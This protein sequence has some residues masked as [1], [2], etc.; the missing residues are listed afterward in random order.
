MTIDDIVR[1]ESPPA[2]WSEGEKIPWDDPAFSERMLREHLSQLHDGASRRMEHIDAHVRWLHQSV[3]GSQPTRILD[4]GCGPGL[5]TVRLAALGHDCVGIDFS[6]ASI[7]YARN[8]SPSIEYIHDDIRLAPYSSAFGML[9][10]IYGE[11]NTFRPSDAQL[12]LSKAHAAL[13]PGGSIVVEVH[14]F[15]VVRAKGMEPA[16][17]RTSS[18][19]LFSPRPHLILEDSFWDAVAHAT[20]HR[21]FIIDAATSEVTR[22]SE[23]MQAYTDDELHRL[24]RSSGFNRV[25]TFGSLSGAS[26][27]GELFVVVASR[28]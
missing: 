20:T 21:Y 26:I 23:S 1:R 8:A 7:A 22:C 15:D 25:D 3:L 14:P 12:I 9:M 4:L 19:G 13:T 6:P 16:T 17:W 28:V 10:L 2:P 11:L 18:G 27:S 5:Y 24:L